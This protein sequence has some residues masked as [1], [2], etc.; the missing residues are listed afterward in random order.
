VSGP[1]GSDVYGRAKG[2][3]TRNVPAVP[4]SPDTGVLV[5]VIGPDGSTHGTWAD[6]STHLS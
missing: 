4:F 5:Q 1:A 2:T 6:N 3:D